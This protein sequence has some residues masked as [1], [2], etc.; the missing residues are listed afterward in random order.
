MNPKIDEILT[1]YLFD[2][3]IEKDDYLILQ[4]WLEASEENKKLFQRLEKMVNYGH[5]LGSPDKNRHENEYRQICKKITSHQRNRYRWRRVAIYQ[6]AAGIVLLISFTLLLTHFQHIDRPSAIQ[7]TEKITPGITKAQLILPDGNHI[8]LTEHLGEMIVSDSLLTIQNDKTGLVYSSESKAATV[9]DYHTLIIPAGAE[10]SLSLSDGT[11]VFLN[12]GSEIRYPSSMNSGTREVY[13]KGEAYFDVQKDPDHPFIV[14]TEEMQ[15][16]VLGTSFNIK[17]YPNQEVAAAT[18]EEGKINVICGNEAH[19]IFPGTQVSYHKNADKTTV[20]TVDTELYTSWRSGYYKFEEML[21]EDILATL[22][23]WYD[24][25]VVYLN[26][27]KKSIE[28]TGQLKRYEN[29]IQ[30]LNKFEQTHEVKF[31]IEGKRVIV[32]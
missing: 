30:L 14:H 8:Q 1:D 13:L 18:L 10:Y 6:A 11:K 15:I 2:V 7:A 32:K 29:V 23:L 9:V 22:S 4:E 20:K 31:T 12:S 26:P 16:K 19:D 3:P 24:M 28:F 21:L 17:A 5:A 27:A 25:E